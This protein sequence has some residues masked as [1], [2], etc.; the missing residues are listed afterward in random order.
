MLK[1][2][3]L[4]ALGLAAAAGA[5]TTVFAQTTIDATDPAAILD[6]AS[7]WGSAN[8]EKDSSGRPKIRGRAKGNAYI[9]WFAGCTDGKNCRLIQLWAGY[10]KPGVT[11]DAI[12]EWN[13]TKRFGKAY[14]TKEGTSILAFNLNLDEGGVTRANLDDTFSL[15]V[16]V[17]M[18][19]FKEHIGWEG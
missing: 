16:N 2:L 9:I 7:G 15:W 5:A 6:V 13:R 11:L 17:I 19:Q 1:A 14:L 3:T 10:K 18:G 4:T 8:M 12:N